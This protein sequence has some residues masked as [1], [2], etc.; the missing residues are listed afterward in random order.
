MKSKYLSTQFLVQFNAEFNIFS[1]LTHILSWVCG[2]IKV[3]RR[4]QVIRYLSSF[5]ESDRAIWLS[6]LTICG[7]ANM[8]YSWRIVLS[9]VIECKK[10]IVAKSAFNSINVFH[11][12][13]H[14]IVRFCLKIWSYFVVFH[15]CERAVSAAQHV[16]H[17]KILWSSNIWMWWQCGI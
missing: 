6:V 5:W 9:Y 13:I 12:L 8:T 17:V 2:L 16:Q 15:I 1:C 4:P 11:S 10:H 3:P 7:L 14:S